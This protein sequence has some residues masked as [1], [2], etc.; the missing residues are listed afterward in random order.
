MR[1]VLV[2][3]SL[4]VGHAH[5]AGQSINQL[6]T[7]IQEAIP[8][9]NK[10]LTVIAEFK[11]KIK[12]YNKLHPDQKFHSYRRQEIV[13]YLDLKQFSYIIEDTTAHGIVF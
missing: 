8:S 7:D 1:T 3:I 13:N 4:I 10:I 5:V 2:L 12:Q 9:E 11:E 6:A